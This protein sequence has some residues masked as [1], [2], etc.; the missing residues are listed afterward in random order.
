VWGGTVRISEL[1]WVG[2]E[3]EYFCKRDWTE[4]I[5]DLLTDLPVGQNQNAST[6]IWRNSKN[7]ALR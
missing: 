5:I 1:I 4:K 3:A 6:S 7:A 2:G